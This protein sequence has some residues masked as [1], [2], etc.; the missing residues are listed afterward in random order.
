MS[1]NEGMREQSERR[2]GASRRGEVRLMTGR[3]KKMLVE[4]VSGKQWGPM[5]SHSRLRNELKRK[6]TGVYYTMFTQLTDQ[7]LSSTKSQVE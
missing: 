2:W 3:L 4:A 6:S 7:I 5:L 1:A